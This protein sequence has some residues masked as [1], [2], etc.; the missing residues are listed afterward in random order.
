MSFSICVHNK[1][2]CTPCCTCTAS[3]GPGMACH[4]SPC[5]CCCA[6]PAMVRRTAGA[7]CRL[8]LAGCSHIR[9]SEAD[10]GADAGSRRCTSVARSRGGWRPSPWRQWTAHLACLQSWYT[11]HQGEQQQQQQEAPGSVIFEYEAR[12]VAACALLCLL[13]Q[14]A[15]TCCWRSCSTQQRSLRSACCRCHT[16]CATLYSSVG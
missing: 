1:E 6:L 5:W 3:L 12:Q 7:G 4:A 10:A 9:L 14:T 16:G 15:L 2:P 13:Q 8:A 11:C